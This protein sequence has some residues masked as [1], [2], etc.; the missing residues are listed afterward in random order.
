MQIIIPQ[1]DII[2]ICNSE[3]YNHDVLRKT[4]LV[5]YNLSWSSCDSAVMGYLYQKYGASPTMP[6]CLDGIFAC[7]IYDENTGEYV[8]FRDPIGICS[9]YWGKSSDGSRWFANEMKALHDVCVTF[10]IFPP[11]HFYDS[12][13]DKLTRFFNSTWISESVIPSNKVDYEVLKVNHSS[14]FIAIFL[15][16]EAVDQSSSKENYD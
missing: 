7:V 1:G 14:I 3:I 9:L 8:A 16:A 5:N 10:D 15:I 13:T 2:W 4:E 12:K 11:G 6:S